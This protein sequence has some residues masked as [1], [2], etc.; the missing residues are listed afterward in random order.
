MQWSHGK[1]QETI[2]ICFASLLQEVSDDGDHTT[3][4]TK[5]NCGNV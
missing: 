4:V 2:A 5:T 1:L 3:V